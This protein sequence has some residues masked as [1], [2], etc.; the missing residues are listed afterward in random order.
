MDEQRVTKPATVETGSRWQL[1]RREAESV[2]TAVVR[3]CREHGG[4]HHA[5]FAHG[6]WDHV[7]ELLTDDRY[8]FLGGPTPTSPGERPKPAKGQRWRTPPAPSLWGLTPNAVFELNRRSYSDNCWKAKGP[9][10]NGKVVDDWNMCDDWFRPGGPL[11]FVDHGPTPVAEQG[12]PAKD[13]ADA[14]L[15]PCSPASDLTRSTDRAKS[16]AAPGEGK[17]R[18]PSPVR[19]ESGGLSARAILQ[20]RQRDRERVRAENAAAVAALCS[21]WDLLP[22]VDERRWRR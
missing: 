6:G 7:S 2:V 11:E 3:G 20:A 4:S 13:S 19:H 10:I 12:G 9:A 5:H 16:A 17:P 15:T 18:L 21:E 14:V 22:S 1:N 8:T